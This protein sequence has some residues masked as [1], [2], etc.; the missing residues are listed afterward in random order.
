MLPDIHSVVHSDIIDS[1]TPIV[2]HKSAQVKN[3]MRKPIVKQDPD[4]IPIKSEVIKQFKFEDS[5][6]KKYVPKKKNVMPAPLLKEPIIKRK[7]IVKKIVEK[8]SEPIIIREIPKQNDEANRIIE[9]F[10]KY[11]VY[12]ETSTPG[13]GKTPLTGITALKLGLPLI[14]VCQAKL[15]THWKSFADAMGF[16]VKYY[17]SYG[18][19]SGRL[20]SINNEFLTREDIVGKKTKTI[21]HTTQKYE[22]LLMEG[23]LLV[24]DESSM[25]KNKAC[26]QTKACRAISRKLTYMFNSVEN[27]KSRTLFISGTPIT[28]IIQIVEFVKTI[29]Y[30]NNEKLFKIVEKKGKKSIEL[31]GIKP[32]V[33]ICSEIDFEQT[34]YIIN[35]IYFDQSSKNLT[36]I[37]VSLYVEILKHEISGGMKSSRI[38]GFKFDVKNKFYN[39]EENDFQNLKESIEELVDYTGYDDYTS[40]FAK[41]EIKNRKIGAK[42]I[43]KKCNEYKIPIVIRECKRVFA[44]YPQEKIIIA[45]EYVTGITNVFRQKLSEYGPELIQGSIKLNE[46][47]Q[48]LE[49]F[50]E[51]NGECRIL[52]ISKAAYHGVS[53]HDTYGDYQH[54]M[55]ILP[56]FSMESLYQASYRCYREG[57]KSNV[58]VRVV[59][60]KGLDI[61]LRI[62]A[63]QG[64]QSGCVKMMLDKDTIENSVF[65]DDYEDKI[66][67]EKNSVNLK[68]K[69]ITEMF[70]TYKLLRM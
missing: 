46:R 63:S 21:F 43:R 58:K 62:I 41:S 26:D 70:E 66:E 52:I 25:V 45:T 64:R 9:C 11:C 60:A 67:G 20:G 65:P 40:T 28:E 37:I 29:G 15:I 16:E 54:R 5:S 1:K 61:E 68:V 19:L 2:K 38:E 57:V 32:L 39:M 51:N 6:I 34:E 50:N 35:Q 59:Y 3:I 4:T 13:S 36:K 44:K 69:K 7:R 24:F 47:N 22:D 14:I 55:Y 8:E 23:I 27:F 31:L 53:M 10:K 30:I 49:K 18:K 33:D 17:I 12:L 42:K 56:D 48:A